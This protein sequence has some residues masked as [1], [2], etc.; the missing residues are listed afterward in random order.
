MKRTLLYSLIL[1]A[2]ATSA[3]PVVIIN[4][5]CTVTPSSDI[6]VKADTGNIIVTGTFSNACGNVVTPPPVEP[7]PV[8]IPTACTEGS[9]IGE[10][11]KIGYTRQCS[12]SVR[13]W[14]TSMKPRPAWD[15]TYEG[16]MSGPWPGNKAQFGWAL[17]MLVKSMGFGSFKFNTG[18]VEAGV[19]FQSN[20]S[21]GVQG[22]ISVSTI[23]GDFEDTTSV[24]KGS[25]VSISS[26]AG[27]RATCKLQLNTD[28]FLNISNANYFPPHETMCEGGNQCNIAWTVYSYGN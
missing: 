21:Y 14:N 5:T 17:S 28:Y 8:E 22:T 2:T 23:P 24:C 10:L 9:P 15:N 25:A 20:T 3:A 4:G 16:L 27:T 12:G 26:K 1:A 7:P 18:Q 6:T 19:T 11:G 13:S